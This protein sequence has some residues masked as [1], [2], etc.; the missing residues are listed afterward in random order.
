MTQPVLDL[1]SSNET[2]SSVSTC[3]P[4]PRGVSLCTRYAAFEAKL[5]LLCL[6][7]CGDGGGGDEGGGVGGSGE[8]GGDEGGDG[9]GGGEEIL[10][11]YLVL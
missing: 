2:F 6:Q 1:C 3:M 4:R 10:H 11:I 7:Y 9:G 5:E 8:G